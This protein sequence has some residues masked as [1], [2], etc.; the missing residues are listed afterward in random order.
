ML[1]LVG[2]TT[3]AIDLCSILSEQESFSLDFRIWR[4][5]NA[6]DIIPRRVDC[7]PRTMPNLYDER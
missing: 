3:L 1:G 2:I 7:F 4:D 5:E 6:R